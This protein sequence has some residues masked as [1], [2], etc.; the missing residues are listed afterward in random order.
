MVPGRRYTPRYLSGLVRRRWALVAV[1]LV[2]GAAL[3]TLIARRLP[4]VFY[5]QATVLIVPQQIP[6]SYVRSTV[7]LP[8]GERLRSTAQDVKS[9]ATLAPLMDEFKLYGNL[10]RT[11]P[12]DAL[13]AW[14]A[15]NVR[16]EQVR[17]DTLIVGF[18]GYD[19]TAVAKVAD[20][21][22]HLFI[23]ATLRNRED[24]A[25]GASRFLDAE[26]ESTRARLAAQER[27]VQEFR[28]TYAGELPTQEPANLQI[29]QGG[30]AQLQ[31]VMEALRQDRDRL[32]QVQQQLAGE[33]QA[34]DDAKAA[35]AAKSEADANAALATPG[36]PASPAP[37]AA[38]ETPE[39]A[40]PDPLRIPAGPADQRL[41]FARVLLVQLLKKYTP[42]HPDVARLQ[43]AIVDLEKAAA[44]GAANARPNTPAGAAIANARLAALDVELNRLEL[45]IAD[46]EKLEKRILDGIAIYQAR[47]EAVPSRESEWTALTRDYQTLQQ[48]YASLLAKKEASRLAANLE[49]QRISEQ[50]KIITPPVTPSQPVSPNRGGIVLVGILLGLGLG[51]VLPIFLELTDSTLRGETEVVAALRLPVLAML[52]RILT[53]ADRR[54]RQLRRV[55]IGIAAAVVFVT[56]AAWHWR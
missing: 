25:D 21:L 29:L 48:S 6:E 54:R 17:P 35:S 49:R 38:G 5:A 9:P 10:R 2:I 19:R 4:D 46:K 36:T 1:P 30:Q 18:S 47:V 41:A 42:E 23:D 15:R 52:P 55:S 20:R 14:M 51:L 39:A 31:G 34:V 11:A 56:A 16:I 28:E 13:V 7:T 33:Q 50:F 12:A 26:V 43:A 27:R 22:V 24:L 40:Q 45:R 37:P 8:I 44:T 32:A 53:R 3:A